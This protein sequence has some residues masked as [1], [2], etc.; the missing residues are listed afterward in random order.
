MRTLGRRAF[1]FVFVTVLID[2]IGFGIIL[3]V[4]PGLIMQLTGVSIDRAARYGGMLS[5]VYAL[6]QFFCAPVLGNLSDR[7]GRRPVILFALLA[8]GVDYIIMGF[9]PAISW[10][11]VGRAI[12][13]VAGSRWSI[14][15]LPMLV[16]TPKHLRFSKVSQRAGRSP[17]GF[18]ASAFKPWS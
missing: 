2:A 14:A 5:F 17:A 8:L 10:L 4:L 6:M 18:C 7:F 16:Y 15:V 13:G 1:L 12:A 9:A 3:P 11:F